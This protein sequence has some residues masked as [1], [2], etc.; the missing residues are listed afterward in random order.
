MPVVAASARP[1]VLGL[2]L[3]ALWRLVPVTTIFGPIVTV[4][5]VETRV[6][7]QLAG[8]LPTYLRNVAEQDVAGGTYDVAKPR[9]YEIVRDRVTKWAEQALPA[10][11]VEIS[12][13][14]ATRRIGSIYRATYGCTIGAVVAGQTRENTRTIAGIYGAAIAAALVQHGDLDGFAD[15]IEWTDTRYDYID[16]DRS[17]TIMAAV[18]SLDVSVNNVLDVAM[19]PS[20]PAPDPEDD[21]IT[22]N[23]G[24]VQTEDTALAL[25]PI[26]DDFP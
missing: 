22:G 12:G 14:L 2:A 19:G 16:E 26:G 18:V 8:W 15:G 9:S 21:P 7:D 23:Y 25:T 20:G 10:V 11:V 4:T 6:R 1:V 13:T 17:R 3:P 24:T 5:K